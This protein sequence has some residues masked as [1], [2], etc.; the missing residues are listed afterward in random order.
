MSETGP[1]SPSLDNVLMVV[2]QNGYYTGFQGLVQTEPLGMEF[3]AGA[4]TPLVQEV[5]FSDLR[6][7]PDNWMK[8][9]AK[10]V[11]DMIGIGCQ[12]TADVPIVK[13]LVE[14]IQK[15]MG[16]DTPPVVIGGHHIGLQPETLF[17][18]GVTAI[19]R[20][21]GEKTMA[22]IVRAWGKNRSLEGVP[23]I[24]YQKEPGYF[25]PQMNPVK[26][27]PFFEYHSREMD[28]R[29]LPRRD[30]VEEFRDGYKFLFYP[31]VQSVESARGCRFRCSFC[32]VWNTHQGEYRVESPNR[33]VQEF[34]SL[35]SG[36]V[37]FVD[38]LAFSD[39]DSASEFAS[40]LK[41]LGIN[42]RFWAQIRA[43]NVTPKD[44]DKLLK[45]RKVFEMLAEAGLDM[46]LIGLESFDPAELK[47]VNKGSQVWQNK[48]TIN[49]LRS[50]GVK[51]WGAQ[52]VFPEWD[53]ADFDKAIENNREL[54][55]EVPQFT[56]LTPLPGTP[57]YKKA[58]EDKQLITDE[59]G[60]FDFFHSVFKTKL[61]LPKFYTEIARLYKETGTW[62][63]NPDGSVADENLASKAARSI[64][65]D[66]RAGI[67]TPEAV[68]RF[69]EEFEA[70]RNEHVHIAQLAKSA[71]MQVG[72][73]VLT[74]LRPGAQEW[75]Q[76]QQQALSAYLSGLPQHSATMG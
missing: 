75:L 71:L 57:D 16:K 41:R 24:W 60:M 68:R 25:Q 62:A 53:V 40:E 20:G 22:N 2:P 12:Y 26:I 17:I 30:L 54:G 11:P 34:A 66:I 42:K 49:F 3:V 59:P 47:R 19:V 69:K 65:R 10:R 70:L 73:D 56:I 31:R 35:D 58:M 44:K 13:E 32:S 43:D 23:N 76:E 52:I 39:I 48:E 50:I 51:I 7:D 18:P 74:K 14:K 37:N 4:I 33:T 67:T 27:S 46:V 5:S 61:S 72:A 28:E 64:F 36:Y 1:K 6:V 21:P 29:P 15:Y 63:I 55:I 45:H 9:I 8:K 38:D